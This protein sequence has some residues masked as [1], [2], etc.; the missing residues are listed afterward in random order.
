M[1]KTVA[2]LKKERE[3][4]KFNFK[5]NSSSKIKTVEELK[6]ERESGKYNIINSTLKDKTYTQIMRDKAKSKNYD[7]VPDDFV[8]YAAELPYKWKGAVT[9][10][11]V[12]EQK[13]APLKS[14]L[15]GLPN[16]PT[17][18]EINNRI[19]E[20]EKLQSGAKRRGVDSTEYDNQ[21]EALKKYMDHNRDIIDTM[22]EDDIRN[23]IGESK[24]IENT[25]SEDDRKRYE[26]LASYN[27]GDIMAQTQEE[28]DK[29]KITAQQYADYFEKK[30]GI[31]PENITLDTMANYQTKTNEGSVAYYDETGKAVTWQEALVIK[32]QGKKLSELQSD[33]ALNSEYKNISELSADFSTLQSALAT[34]ED[35]YDDVR[36]YELL[37]KYGLDNSEPIEFNLVKLSKNLQDSIAS[38]KS[39]LSNS[40]YDWDELQKYNEYLKDKEAY[41][42]Q[43]AKNEEF[44]SEH[45]FLATGASI[46][47]S[48]SQISDLSVNAMDA[49]ASIGKDET[50]SYKLTNP[51]D[52]LNVNRI[53]TQNAT[54]TNLI[55]KKVYDMT[56]N[57]TLSWLA[58]TAYSGGT[59]AAQSALTGTVSSLLFGPEAGPAVALGLLSSQSAS[60]GF[61]RTAMNGGTYGEAMTTALADGVAEAMFEKLSLDSFINLKSGLDTST[62][63]GL[64][65]STLRNSK[66]VLVHSLIE[67]SEELMTECATS[68]A[69]EII[70]GDHSDYSIS[71]DKYMQAGLSEEEAKRKASADSVK[72]VL[73]AT[74]GGFIGGFGAGGAKVVANTVVGGTD[75]VETSHKNKAVGNQIASQGNAEIAINKALD[76]PDTESNKKVR[77]LARD[78]QDVDVSK[79]SKRGLKEYN[80]KLGQLYDML[81]ASSVSDVINSSD[82]AIKDVIKQKLTEYGVTERTDEIASAIYKEHKGQETNDID[83]GLIKANYGE[84]II[85]YL[86]DNKSEV[87]EAVASRISESYRNFDSVKGLLGIEEISDIDIE[88]FNLSDD[89]KTYIAGTS[90]AV[91]IG[92]IETISK[93]DIIVS[94]SDGSAESVKNLDLGSSEQ[95][96]LY[97][98]VLDIQS[99]LGIKLDT[100]TANALVT[101][102]N[103]MN[104]DAKTYV[105]DAKVAIMKGYANVSAN[106]LK[107]N[108]LGDKARIIYDLGVK[109]SE[110]EKA[111]RKKAVANKVAPITKAS[112]TFEDI[113]RNNLTERQRVSVNAVEKLAESTEVN[114]VFFRSEK[115]NGKYTS[116]YDTEKG[117]PNGFYKASTNT[118]YLDINAGATGKG[119]ILFTAAHELTH[120]IREWS[121]ESFKTFAD[122]LAEKYTAKGENFDALIRAKMQQLDLT[123]DEAYEEVVA[124]SCESFLIDSN[125]IENV[126]ELSKRDMNLAT[127]IKDFLKNLL[128]RVREVYKKLSPD[129]YEGKYVREMRDSLSELHGKWIQGIKIATENLNNA[130]TGAT[131]NTANNDGVKFSY[132]G[133]EAINSDISLLQK[134][135]SMIENGIDSETVRKETGWFRGYDGKWR[136]EIDDSEM[137]FHFEGL[138]KNPDVLRFKELQNKFINADITDA[139]MNEMNTLKEALKGVNIKLKTISDRVVHNKL[140]KAYPQLKDIKL[141]FDTLDKN[142]KGKYS[143]QN[144]TITLNNNLIGDN[145]QIR[146]TL[147]HEMQH[148]IQDIE[149]FT[150]GASVEYWKNQRKEINELIGGA[151]A[152]LDL[153]LDDIGYN[154]FV[155]KS[156]QE[157]V[158]KEK[159]L[160]QHWEDCRRFKDNSKFAKQIA[161]CEAEIAEYERQRKEITKGMNVV[162]QYLN[163]AGEIEARDTESRL[164][165]SEKQRKNTRPDID[166]TSVVFADGDVSNSI[167]YTTQ[168]EP[169]VVVKDDILSG[170][171]KNDWVKT[172]KS[173]IKAK[174]SNG[175]PVKGRLIKVN[176]KSRQEFTNS[177]YSKYL[178]DNNSVMYEDKLKSSGHLDEIV[179][180]STNY[181]NE[182]LKHVRNDSFV[183]FARGDVL[184]RIGDNDYSAKVIVGF[185]KKAEM[186]LYDVIELNTTSFDIKKES[187]PNSSRT[188][189]SGVPSN[190]I[191]PQG[192]NTVNN[193]SMQKD[194]KN[195]LR[196]NE[197]LEAVNNGD[198]ETAQRMVDEYA[199][200]VF[201][202]SKI[203]D[204][205]GKLLK[206]YHGT[207]EDFTVFDKTKGRTNMDIQGMFFSPWDIDAKGYGPNVRAFYLNITNPANESTGYKA[208]R[209]Y[210]SQNNAGVK[211]R[212]YLEKLGYD[213][214]NNENEEFIAFN[215]EQIKSADPVTYDDNGDVIPLSKRFDFE[216]EDIRYQA[217]PDFS[218]IL[219]D[220]FD[221]EVTDDD[222]RLITEYIDGN[223]DTISH[224]LDKTKAIELTEPKIK[225]LV[226]RMLSSYDLSKDNQKAVYVA[227]LS[228]LE[229]TTKREVLDNLE[230]LK[231]ALTNTIQS[232]SLISEYDRTQRADVLEYLREFRKE[233]SVYLNDEQV[234]SLEFQGRS[235]SWLKKELF[236][237]VSIVKED[238]DSSKKKMSFGY[239]W[240]DISEMFPD[241]F[242]IDHTDSVDNWEMFLEKLNRIKNPPTMTVQ[243]AFG[244]TDDELVNELTGRL[245]ADAVEAKY[246]SRK[247]AYVDTLIKNLRKK[248]NENVHKERIRITQK[249]KNSEQKKYDRLVKE[250]KRQRETYTENRNKT[251]VRNKIR[252]K[253]KQLDSYLNH[254]NK[255]K[256]VKEG[257]RAFVSRALET[258]DII[259]SNEISNEDILRRG[260]VGMSEKE[261]KYYDKCRQYLQMRESQEELYAKARDKSELSA[262]RTIQSQIDEINKKL[263]QN[264]A[265]LRE[266]FAREKAKLYE[267]PV[268]DALNNLA[269]EYSK[270][271]NS[272]K[273]YVS[274][275]YDEDVL[276]MINTLKDKIGDGTRAR[277][278]TLEQLVKVHDVYTAVLSAVRNANKLFL[279][280]NSVSDAGEHI[281]EELDD[282]KKARASESGSKRLIEKFGVDSLKPIYFFRMLGSKTFENLF[283]NL[284]KGELK[285]YQNVSLVKEFRKQMAEKYNYTSW[286]FES[287]ETFTDVFGNEFSLSLEE[288]LS[289]CA[290]WRREQGREHLLRDGFVFD[291]NVKIK[292]KKKGFNVDS[293]HTEY[294]A[295]SM[296]VDIVMKIYGTLTEEQKAY[297]ED[298]Q[299]YLSTDMSNL[300]NEVSMK[301]Y[302]IKQFKEAFY[303]PIKVSR[304]HL[305]T[306]PGKMDADAKLK[307]SGFTHNTVPKSGNPIVLSEFST[308]W[309]NHCNRMCQYNAFVLPLEDLT[310]VLNYRVS[311]ATR[312]NSAD[313]LKAEI[314]GR[315][316]NGAVQYLEMLIQD[317][318]GSVRNEN[319][320][321][322][323]KLISL[324][325]KGSV[326]AS[327]SVT[328]QQPFAMY[329]ALSLI[330]PKYYPKAMAKG[331]SF[332]KHNSEFEE[333]KKYAPVAGIKEMGYF[334]VGI[335]QKTTDWMLQDEYQG[336][337]RLKA[338]FTDS[339]YRDDILSIPPAKADEVAWLV[340]WRAVKS[341]I[342]D[343]TNLTG[344]EYLNR[345]GERFNE[346]IH[347]TQVYDS[348]LSRSG[349]M[350]N[351][352]A[353]SKM[354]TAYMAEP[355]VTMNMLVDATIQAERIGKKKGFKAK[356]DHIVRVYSTIAFTQVITALAK[357]LVLAG[358]DDDEDETYIEKYISAASQEAL[359]SLNP[360]GW[361][362]L[363]RDVLS[364]IQGYDIER[365]DMSLISDF[366]DSINDLNK[367]LSADDSSVK[368]ITKDSVAVIS[369]F[370]NIFGVPAKNVLRDID[371][372]INI[373]KTFAH[374][375]DADI[376]SYDIKEAFKE[377]IWD[378]ETK[379]IERAKSAY[380]KGNTNVFH[381]TISDMIQDKVDDGKTEKEAKSSVR[382]QF[383]RQCKEDYLRLYV[384]ER[385]ISEA[386]EIR[387][388]LLATGLYGSLGELDKDL[389]QWRKDYNKNK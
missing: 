105:M 383:T 23:V 29:N 300:G 90:N 230:L 175:I 148:A 337:E 320:E 174:F 263:R 245:V 127:K 361:I 222:A 162:D 303:F 150:A 321:I 346:I 358:R 122:F 343:T 247:N 39:V 246:N 275:A 190:S 202:N 24:D 77:G 238:S 82:V 94:L 364:I 262:M 334:D 20:L 221:G 68:V 189:R 318:N 261:Q 324:S 97:Q 25:F 344:A 213:G 384:D 43:K 224:I 151:R 290:L 249:I 26:W 348:V 40:G 386:N 225:S 41:L 17:Y 223:A 79:L 256:N 131:K 248:H 163:T 91:E 88:D 61:N 338:F 194:S 89:G 205:D 47:S 28:H 331:L 269:D 319:I 120:A 357:S 52:D 302:G 381:D 214:V 197:Y 356:L 5:Q 216:N 280:D 272:D 203:R 45:P 140:F 314:S 252:N 271:E 170:I 333:L 95:A 377:G 183:E 100:S 310:K 282:V 18:S 139:E 227:T 328:I 309:A 16:N 382:S 354:V 219:F 237:L 228:L 365:T 46:L 56:D 199:E 325:K 283:W 308:V 335:G 332:T 128:Q 101:G 53:N 339:G 132:A 311:S 376:N 191:I 63:R 6:N 60:A 14:A 188:V 323:D 161:N 258:A 378:K 69:D 113:D 253:I 70:N 109:L 15:E 153:W 276:A 142:T 294:K 54:V 207:Y 50:S 336:K 154:E 73:Q 4:G 367:T 284:Q 159:T 281:Y 48:P 173:I 99:D 31:K 169:V 143:Y 155:K 251:A 317:I 96:V 292:G 265:Q 379:K 193:N 209:V 186:V 112:V 171:S 81:Q 312:G 35:N 295:H 279:I 349:L 76:L 57:E 201:A 359:Q 124:D 299:K 114:F 64:M 72:Q 255:K 185:T 266:L 187:T 306:D 362:P 84:E 119:T 1:A 67:G 330:S 355:T 285:W 111:R 106:K 305:N 12:I 130:K 134:A 278:M 19:S 389:I 44:A 315:W 235:V 177:K 152:N 49:I 353:M 83:R 231:T 55:D 268:V 179:L 104:T 168:N 21:M 241:I 329:R 22:S 210:I 92:K 260:V 297:M 204:E 298:M 369:S 156:M 307:S 129:S 327:A 116:K 157:V 366:V 9:P 296:S 182:D 42:E 147:I 304:K 51:Y 34:S 181:I 360:I 10:D 102:Y 176:Q 380:D 372:C 220:E 103:N 27:N 373:V 167:E 289:L 33:P 239:F 351:K 229:S 313:A 78:I 208:L 65:N 211:A 242:D 58:S 74:I 301:L 123:Y 135:Q 138:N 388:Y 98:G 240:H 387:K 80:K 30:H 93:D 293:Y 243:E 2:Q 62:F 374:S 277:D 115:K 117:S 287:L 160:E 7:K 110:N 3:N 107:T 158:S 316:G 286:E 291:E 341:E 288:K 32:H 200:E 363:G 86:N 234:S 375:K 59:S 206:F 8:R 145:E 236:P 71:V 326:M 195:S 218:D 180:A 133:R 108:V 270:I 37:E 164:N 118:V 126:E 250:H 141:V 149:G 254:G 36:I 322:V 347:L 172:A 192:D 226:S 232:S 178:R 345:C 342:K 198:M 352:D 368:E 244:I 144:K 259:F 121:P 385:N 87:E 370:A 217:R 38:K 196:D 165:L 350:R 85:T 166:R 125:L 13:Y 264:K 215:S 146:K 371:T 136:F 212:G 137:E 66:N 233:Y 273:S 75:L 274:N 340:I 257:M 184:M 11:K 267:I